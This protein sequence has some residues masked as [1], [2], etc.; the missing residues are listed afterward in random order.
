MH[1]V[2]MYVRLLF[3]LIYSGRAN[4]Q[5]A[6][7]DLVCVNVLLKLIITVYNVNVLITNNKFYNYCIFFIKINSI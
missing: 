4:K 1:Y 6:K 3:I 2:Y 7:K 5:S